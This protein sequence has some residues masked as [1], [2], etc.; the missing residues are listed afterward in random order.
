MNL[1]DYISEAWSILWNKRSLWFF[2]LLAALGGSGFNFNWHIGEPQPVTDLPLGAQTLLQNALRSNDTTT[3]ILIGLV[4]GLAMFMLSTLAQGALIDLVGNLQKRQETTIHRGLRAGWQ[5]F[6]PLLAVRS[7]LALPLIVVGT[8]AAHSIW[9][10]LSRLFTEPTGERLFTFGQT[11]QLAGMGGLLL[12]ISLL[13]AA[14]DISAERA[15]VLEGSSVGAA[16]RH[17]WQLLWHNLLDYL[18]LGVIFLVAGVVVVLTFAVLLAPIFFVA[19]LTSLS[20]GIDVVNAFT[21]TTQAL[22]ALTIVVFMLALV[23]STLVTV[24]TA[25][26][27][28]IA[29][30]EWQYKG[31]VR[32]LAV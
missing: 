13:I 17:S 23:L 2:G 24:F 3:L 11:G 16:L 20:H 10:A 8:L 27:W 14:L 25:S 5:Y 6:L 32:T 9:P 26:V 30:Q 15:V 21:F 28:T 22:G 7:L 19:S 1:W 31:R 4:L 12:A 29:Y 18:A